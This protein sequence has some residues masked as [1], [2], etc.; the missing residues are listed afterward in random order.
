MSSSSSS[1]SVS[2]PAVVDKH[3]ALLKTVDQC[4]HY[5]CTYVATSTKVKRFLTFLLFASSLNTVARTFCMNCYMALIEASP[6]TVDCR[7]GVLCGCGARY[8]G[9]QCLVADAQAHKAS[10]DKVQSALQILAKSR[11]RATQNT[12]HVASEWGGHVQ[13]ELFRADMLVSASDVVGALV[14]VAESLRIA[15]AFELAQ[16]FG[17]RA[18]S[19][20]AKGS[21]DEAMALASL[22]NVANALSKCDVAMAHYEAV[23]KIRKRLLGENHVEVACLYSSMSGLFAKLKRLDEAL[24]MCSSALAIFEKAPGCIHNTP[25]CHNNMGTILRHQGKIDEAMKHY[26]T[27]LAITLKIEGETATAADFLANIGTAFVDQNKLDDAAEKFFSALRIYEK[28]KLDASSA[29]CH[30]NIASVLEKQGKLAAALEHARKSLVLKR[31]KL[32]HEHADCGQSHILIGNILRRGEK[33]AAA[34]D[35]YENALRINKNV[36]GEMTL[37]VANNYRSMAICFVSLQ[38][39]REAVTFFEATIHIRTVLLGAG[40]ASLVELKEDLAVA[41]E[42]L[43][44]ERSRAAA[45]ERKK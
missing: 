33:F 21:L 39:W 17:Q 29:T 38:K 26:S 5:K 45:S 12:M 9:I 15:E 14:C 32:S 25:M 7:L 28:A 16:K 37:Q 27:G 34:L 1:S 10:C 24:A 2:A 30:H 11:F 19:V 8:C 31:S 41:E 36:F 40:D 44:A 35:E 4:T 22:A 23:L 20:S 3:V 6:K 42:Q 43:K 13:I 18:L